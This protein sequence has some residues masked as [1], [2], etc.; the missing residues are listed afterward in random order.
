MR[1]LIWLD[2]AINDLTRLRQ[3]IADKNPEAAARAA[4]TIIENTQLILEQPFIGKP[5]IDPPEYRDHYVRF[6][7]GGYIL[8]YRIH[9]DDVYIVHLRHYRETCFKK[10]E[11]EGASLK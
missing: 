1:E 7:A 11:S 3:F 6:G 10:S 5:V 9:L 8:R 2:S 4:K